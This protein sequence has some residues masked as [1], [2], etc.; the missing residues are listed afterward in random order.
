MLN[1]FNNKIKIKFI[2]KKTVIYT[3]III[4]FIVLFIY[5]NKNKNIK[6]NFDDN[7]VNNPTTTS[8]N[9]EYETNK[10]VYGEGNSSPTM[11]NSKGCPAITNV[12]EFC[13]NYDDCCNNKS[14]YNA[15]FCKNPIVKTCKDKYD[16]CMKDSK[17]SEKCNLDNINCCKEYNNIKI[18]SDIF[19]KPIKNNQKDNLLCS[20]IS[21]K[22][23]RQ[24]C[25][26]LCQTTPEC[27]AYST[28]NLNCNLFNNV[29]SIN[30]TYDPSTGKEIINPNVDFFIK[31]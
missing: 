6:S 27:K 22:N 20:I 17:S 16:L 10:S 26:E 8:F 3:V 1:I 9:I 12:V 23:I 29:S 5:L 21:I 11:G 30:R 2:S 14:E 25:L 15:C 13:I 31:K 28:T 19:E 24:K 4:S 7:P 18:N